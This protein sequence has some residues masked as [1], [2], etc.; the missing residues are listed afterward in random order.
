[1]GTTTKVV[2]GMTEAQNTAVKTAFS[3]ASSDML[4]Q[5]VDY[6]PIMLGVAVAGF[7]VYLGMKLVKKVRKGGK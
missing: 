5:F 1:M 6:V 3:T 7:A 2:S 4:T